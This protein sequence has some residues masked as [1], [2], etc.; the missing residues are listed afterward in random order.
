MFQLAFDVPPI[1]NDEELPAVPP[2]AFMTVPKEE[3]PPFV[4]GIGALAVS[5]GAPMFNV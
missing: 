3:L 1:P 2:F 4:E 5:P